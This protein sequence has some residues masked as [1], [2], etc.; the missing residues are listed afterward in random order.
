MLVMIMLVNITMAVMV[1]LML[2]LL[3]APPG[4][5]QADQHCAA[6]GRLR[7]GDRAMSKKS[8]ANKRR[9]A[10][11]F[12]LALGAATLLLASLFYSA[13]FRNFVDQATGWAKEIM[14]AH[15]VTGA[16]VFFL[17]SAVSAMLAFASNAV[18]VPPANLVWGKPLTFLL[19]WGG[20]IAGAMAAYGI[21]KLA[22][23]LLSYVG[24][25]ETLDEYQQF[26]SKR[27]KFWAVLLFCFAVP[28]E[29]PGYLFGGVHYPFLKFLAAIA[30]AE[31]VYALGLV[32]AGESLV[33]FKPL[34]LV[35]TVGILIVIAVGAGLLLRA[36]KKR[37]SRR[38]R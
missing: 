36:L 35:A 7:S 8:K 16:A 23:P 26:V 13:T 15:P 4:S 31:S 1:M 21:G 25:K 28:S 12:W 5:V 10:V 17:F 18:L 2:A 27:M 11:W 14:N 33:A 37:K 20:W 3:S 32:V 24:Y 29:V 9:R 6:S 38:Q 22:R 30:I 34:P 19:L